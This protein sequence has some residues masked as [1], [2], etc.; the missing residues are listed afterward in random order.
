MR[1]WISSAL[2]GIII[3]MPTSVFASYDL[4]P[5]SSVWMVWG[6]GK[7]TPH[8]HGP[9]PNQGAAGFSQYEAAD[10]ETRG[11]WKFALTALP[12]DVCEV[13][14]EFQVFVRGLGD[15]S[16]RLDMS[17]MQDWEL[18]GDAGQTYFEAADFETS[19]LQSTIQFAPGTGDY[20]LRKFVLNPSFLRELIRS[21]EAYLHLMIRS[22]TKISG[23]TSFAYMR[24]GRLLVDAST[25]CVETAETYGG[26]EFPAGAVSFV[27]RVVKYDY[28]FSG[29]SYRY[30]DLD[31]AQQDARQVLG[32]PEQGHLSIGRGGRIR[33][34]FVDNSLTVS[35]DDRPDLYI[36]ED[37]GAESMTVDISKDDK[38][39][40]RIGENGRFDA[41]IDIDQFGFN[42]TDRFAFVRIT[43]TTRQGD[44]TWPST[45]SDI[46]AVGARSSG[47]PVHGLPPI[48]YL[49]QAHV[50]GRSDLIIEG[51]RLQW[52]H[53]AGSAP[54]SE[55]QLWSL[56]SDSSSPTIIDSNLGPNITWVP[57]GW[58]LNLAKGNHPDSYSSVFNGLTPVFPRNGRCW[59]LEK[60]WGDGTA[61]IVQQPNASNGFAMVIRFDD[62]IVGKGGGMSNLAGSGFYVVKLSQTFKTC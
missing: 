42:S 14:A 12:N 52:H 54:G 23:K 55:R 5:L 47:P 17:T 26:V 10:S 50:G 43:D 27:D 19:N 3:G 21:D 20:R 58:P 36:F 24:N 35:G 30:D 7:P 16:D 56:G 37:G 1:V 25:G 40:Y 57:Y 46:L 45:G 48:N 18:H 62:L 61:K 33:L 60:L 4:Q 34:Q 49:I 28:N 2:V 51:S 13:S 9:Y 44:D 11:I 31:A 38:S 6:A 8:I 39:W 29:Y 15:D 32:I 41:G 53:R 59:R 22:V